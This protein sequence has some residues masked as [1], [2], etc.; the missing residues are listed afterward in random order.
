MLRSIAANTVGIVQDPIEKKVVAESG[1][2]VTNP[3]VGGVEPDVQEDFK[4]SPI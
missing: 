1:S 2:I 3:E 4:S